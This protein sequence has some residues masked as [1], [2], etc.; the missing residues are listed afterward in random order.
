VLQHE[1]LGYLR[2]LS[3]GHNGADIMKRRNHLRPDRPVKGAAGAVVHKGQ[4]V[5]GNAEGKLVLP[6]KAERLVLIRAQI[7]KGLEGVRIPD[8]VAG[9]P[10]PS[11]PVTL[12]GVEILQ[13]RYLSGP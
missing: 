9:V 7:H 12:R 4:V 10:L 8:N 3:V 11:L 2:M 6:G 5:G 13:D 1:V